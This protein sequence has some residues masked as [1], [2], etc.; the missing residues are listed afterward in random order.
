MS[1]S[2]GGVLADRAANRATLCPV[3]PG[4]KSLTLL[5]HIPTTSLSL[6]LS[7]LVV[8]SVLHL[9]LLASSLLLYSMWLTNTV[10]LEFTNFVCAN[11]YFYHLTLILPLPH[12][13]SPSKQYFPK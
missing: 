8:G 7:A 2:F 4:R 5:G 6:P 12:K 13:R 11:F 1:L 3:Q 10:A 9:S